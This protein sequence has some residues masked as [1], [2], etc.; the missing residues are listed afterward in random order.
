MGRVPRPGESRWTPEDTSL[1]VEWQRLQS[2]MC[3]GCGQPLSESLDEGS[4][5]Q[6]HTITCFACQAKEEAEKSLREAENTRLEGR[7]V[8]AMYAGR[9]PVIPDLT[10]ADGE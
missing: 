8:T 3:G 7:K 2:E 9:R 6:V 10:P 1:A 4:D 5:Y